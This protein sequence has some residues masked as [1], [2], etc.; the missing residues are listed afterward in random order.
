MNPVL[1][2]AFE[3]LIEKYAELLI[4]SASPEDVEKV[5]KWALYSHIHKTM[6]ALAAHWSQSHPE[7][8][9]EMRKLFEDVKRRN[10]ALRAARQAEA[11]GAGDKS[12]T[13]E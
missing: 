10:E 7:A 5:R 13:S 11:P 9:Q 6:P 4:G 2:R 8:R 3:S 12:R 1:D